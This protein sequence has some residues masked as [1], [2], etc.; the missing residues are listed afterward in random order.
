MKF[1]K[2]FA[3]YIGC[4]YAVSLNSC[5]SALEVSLKALGIKKGDDVVVPSFTWVSSANA[6][7]TVEQPIFCDCDIQTRNVTGKDLEKVITKKTKALMIVHYGGQPCNMD[8]IIKVTKKYKIHLIEDS[9]ETLEE[10]GK[11]KKL[12]VLV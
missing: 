10:N 11:K 3:N 6:I 4:K 1:E 7:V 9:A 8:E 5:T 2:A 12:E